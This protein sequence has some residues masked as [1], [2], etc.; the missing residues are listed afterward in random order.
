MEGARLK[1][2]AET[3]EVVPGESTRFGYGGRSRSNENQRARN[4]K[5]CRAESRRWTGS[6]RMMS[7]DREKL[8]REKESI[9][10]ME[11]T[12]WERRR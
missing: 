11:C 5:P 8:V 4:Q 2:Q 6:S 1:E 9:S 10:L 7:S 3:P 12:G